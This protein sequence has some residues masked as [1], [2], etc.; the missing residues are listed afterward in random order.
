MKL[1]GF[2]YKMHNLIPSTPTVS[3]AWTHGFFVG[4]HPPPNWP[5]AAGA[6]FPLHCTAVP[7]DLQAEEDSP[8]SEEM[9]RRPLAGRGRTRRWSRSAPSPCGGPTAGTGTGR[10]ARAWPPSARLQPRDRLRGHV[11]AQPEPLAA[12]V[13]PHPA[14]SARHR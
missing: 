13:R 4:V 8:S 12:G 10:C 6:A 14:S 5:L 1:R 3:V 7:D 9:K 11:R 2:F